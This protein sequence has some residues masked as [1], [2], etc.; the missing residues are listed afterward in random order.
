MLI[1]LIAKK[2]Q[3][4]KLGIRQF[5]TSGDPYNSFLSENLTVLTIAGS[6]IGLYRLASRLHAGNDNTRR[7]KLASGKKSTDNDHKVISSQG[8]Q[9]TSACKISGHSL[10]VFPGKCPKTSNLTCFTKSK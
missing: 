3:L 10:H 8:G 4:T 5:L 9:D 6:T 1:R 2:A 7:P